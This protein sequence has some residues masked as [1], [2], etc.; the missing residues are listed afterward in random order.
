MVDRLWVILLQLKCS[1]TS[2]VYIYIYLYQSDEDDKVILDILLTLN[3]VSFE[4]I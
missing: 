2:M 1:F 4:H 3:F